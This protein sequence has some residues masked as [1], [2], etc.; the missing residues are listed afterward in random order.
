VPDTEVLRGDLAVAL[1]LADLAADVA[2][3]VYGREFE[4][5][6]K[7]DL[8][9]VTEADV[10][11]EQLIRDE[12]RGRCPGDAVLGEE[13]G[14]QGSAERGR[15][16]VIDPIDGTKNFAAGIQVWA[17]LIALTV[18]GE[19]VV[20]VAS[21]PALG[22]R[23][24]AVAGGGARLNGEPIS[25]SKVSDLADALLCST[26]THALVDTPWERPYLELSRRV[27][28]AR[29]FGDFWGH[30]LVARGSADA[31]IEPAL[32]TWDWAA[33]KVIVEE[34]GGRVTTFE[35]APLTDGGS[36]LTTN[37]ALHD[38]LIR[39]LTG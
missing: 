37:G 35:G 9:P 12:L 31:M 29:G 21:A 36:V 32:R 38:E 26:G 17:T 4:V 11:V 6:R 13:G 10:R 30:A 2:M 34:A 15:M 24:D 7:P 5:R 22:E 27:Y 39:R 16:W 33:M 20:G 14:L 3:E 25:V 28:R 18:D 8:S 23:Y 19:A 1:E